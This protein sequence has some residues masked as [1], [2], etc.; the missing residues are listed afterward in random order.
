MRWC[1]WGGQR[2]KLMWPGGGSMSGVDILQCMRFRRR[3]CSLLLNFLI[4]WVFGSKLEGFF[5][6]EVGCRSTLSQSQNPRM[7]S[8]PLSCSVGKTCKGHDPTSLGNTNFIQIWWECWLI[9]SSRK[10]QKA[11]SS[12]TSGLAS[13]LETVLIYCLQRPS[14][15]VIL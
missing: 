4:P 12:I 6:I 15:F 7:C 8:V 5:I 2:E 11:L 14:S 9:S 13:N 1:Q 3:W 10:T